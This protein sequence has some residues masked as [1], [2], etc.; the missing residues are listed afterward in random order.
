MD[1]LG[2]RGPRTIGRQ[3]LLVLASTFVESVEAFEQ[4]LVE[5]HWILNLRC[6]PQSWELDQLRPS[7]AFCSTLAEL[8]VVAQ[9]S[10][11]GWWSKILADSCVVF[12]PNH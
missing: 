1:Y 7:Y 10:A 4:S 2:P 9:C 3:Q 11:N 8:R 12:V 5:G 6:M